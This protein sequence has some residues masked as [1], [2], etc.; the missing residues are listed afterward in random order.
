V[1]NFPLK[2]EKEEEAHWLVVQLQVIDVT[3][4]GSKRAPVKN[5][6]KTPNQ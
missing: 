6:Q 1:V 4:L 3:S 2:K 5:S